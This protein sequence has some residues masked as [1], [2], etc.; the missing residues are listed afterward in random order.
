MPYAN[1]VPLHKAHPTGERHVSVA[2]GKCSMVGKE[3]REPG[4]QPSLGKGSAGCL[5]LFLK[6]QNPREGAES[7][8]ESRRVG[9]RTSEQAARGNI[10][11]VLNL[12]IAP[13]LKDPRLVI[14]N[15]RV[16]SGP[17]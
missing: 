7:G 13:V 15:L 2:K 1:R 3:A 14:I 12:S 11:T 16:L 9:W 5:C 17:R 4:S 8:R 10:S 6:P